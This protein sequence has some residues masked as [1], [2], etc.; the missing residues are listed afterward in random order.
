MN[1]LLKKCDSLFA[2]Y[3]QIECELVHLFGIQNYSANGSC[4]QTAARASLASLFPQLLPWIYVLCAINYLC[5]ALPHLRQAAFSLSPCCMGLADSHASKEHTRQPYNFDTTNLQSCVLSANVLIHRKELNVPRKWTKM[6]QILSKSLAA[7]T[8]NIT[9]NF[10]KYSH[11]AKN[12]PSELPAL[13]ISCTLI[14]FKRIIEST[15]ASF[16]YKLDVGFFWLSY[17]PD[18]AYESGIQRKNS[19]KG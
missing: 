16:L 18:I 15:K 5:S 12:N 4:Q 13:I 6:E 3:P 14:N 8:W 19:Q 2:N 1:K 7:F 9:N 10:F 11:I 17:N